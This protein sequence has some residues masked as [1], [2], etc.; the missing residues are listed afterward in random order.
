MITDL[1]IDAAIFAA[2]VLTHASVIKFTAPVVADVESDAKAI[3]AKLDTVAVEK[4]A[5]TTTK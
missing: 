4:S 5:S 2:G 3:A 1:L